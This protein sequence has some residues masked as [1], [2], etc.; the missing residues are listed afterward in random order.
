[1][2]FVGVTPVQYLHGFFCS[3]RRQHEKAGI[4]MEGGAMGISEMDAARLFFF[5]CFTQLALMVIMFV[6]GYTFHRQIEGIAD[7]RHKGRNTK[8]TRR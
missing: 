3:A 1:M 5:V 7:R 8:N 6:T 4:K 2:Q